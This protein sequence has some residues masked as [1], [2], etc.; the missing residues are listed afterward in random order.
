LQK[1]K[2]RERKK[3][4]KKKEEKKSMSGLRLTEFVKR[5]NPGSAGK[6]IKINA[7]FFEITQLPNINVYHY[8]V[9]ITP[10]VP[11]LVNRRVF[12]HML[13]VHGKSG[14]DGSRPVFDGRK[15]IFSPR[16]FPFDSKTFDVSFL[17]LNAWSPP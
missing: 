17:F 4:K 13:V 2:D 8:D 3:K 6:A 15:N 1:A 12:E 10:D 9:T 5:P 14:L 16:V 7:N 11:P